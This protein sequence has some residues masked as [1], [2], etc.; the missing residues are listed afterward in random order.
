MAYERTEKEQRS[1]W[2][3][4]QY[5]CCASK[6]DVDEGR[7]ALRATGES[8][9]RIC[10][11]QPQCIPQPRAEPQYTRPPTS[12]S[13]GRHVSQWVSSSRDFATR[14]SSRA[15]IST[16]TRPRRSQSRPSISHPTDFR[17]FD[18][19]DGIQSMVDDAP[20]PVRRRRSFRPLELSIYLPDGCGRL[21][22]LP[23]F[24]EI[25]VPAQA[26]V[27]VRDSRTDSL[28][29]NPSSSSYLIQRKA[30]GSGSR[31]SSVQSQ[32][33]TSTSTQERRLSGTTMATMAT[34]TLPLLAE[35]P[36]SSAGSF[37]DRPMIQRSRTSGTL[38]P[39]RVISRL[40]SP[41]R[42]RANTAPSR[43]GSLRRTR[44]DVD[45]AIRELNTIVEE[46]RASAYRS[47]TQSPSLVNPPPT[48]SSHHVPYIAPSM[49]MHVRSETL[50]DIGSAFSAPLGKPLPHLPMT[51]NA[52][53]RR[54]TMGLTLAPPTRSYTGPLTS[55]PITPPAPHTP[56][57][58]ISRLGAWIKRS[59]STIKSAS[60]PATPKTAESFYQYEPALPTTASRPSTAG[61]RTITHTRQESQESNGTATVTLFSSYTSSTRSTSPSSDKNNSPPHK[62]KRVPA[63]LNLAKEKEIAIEA[64]LASA[65]STR[66]VM[67]AKP[68]MSP[69]FALLRGMEISARDVGVNG[70]RRS[71]LLAPSPSAVGMAF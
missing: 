33:S 55:N 29:S 67:N 17:R 63:P 3:A 28:S 22:P 4:M 61:S 7:A 13:M 62:A 49:R 40:P 10:F 60:R 20:M 15:S 14:A 69:N 39:A 43:P 35:E 2:V 16:V 25:E 1:S 18:G 70:E 31:R 46:R 21:S 23:D 32:L 6:G 24:E 37:N 41:S 19:V 48:S 9:M 53:A 58:P 64:A 71:A 30:V 5:G 51:E 50:S 54:A 45:D 38:S 56:T 12:Q 52:P 66:S 34:P 27:R 8:D 68:P 36:K 47:Q 11:E 65:R 57:T 42:N 59:T 44:T 26:L